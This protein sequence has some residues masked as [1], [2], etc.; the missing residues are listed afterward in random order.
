MSGLTNLDSGFILSTFFLKLP[1]AKLNAT[2]SIGST[3]K[4]YTMYTTTRHL[5]KLEHAY[6]IF[7]LPFTIKASKYALTDDLKDVQ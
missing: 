4:M 2:R 1:I 6:I 3:S 5:M 7:V